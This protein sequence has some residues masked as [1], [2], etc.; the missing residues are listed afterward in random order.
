MRFF[1]TESKLPTVA[2][3]AKKLNYVQHKVF[4]AVKRE[5]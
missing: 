1:G 2:R 5:R 4:S 3:P